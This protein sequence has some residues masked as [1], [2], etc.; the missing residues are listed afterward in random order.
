[1]NLSYGLDTAGT[2]P[3]SVVIAAT[4]ETGASLAWTM[5]GTTW[6]PFTGSFV[7]KLSGTAKVRAQVVGKDDSIASLKPFT[8]YHAN[9]APTVGLTAASLS[10]KSYLGT[11]SATVAKVTDWGIGDEI[12]T[13]TW[14]VQN[15]D[16]VDT[17]FVSKL[18]V[19]AGGKLS[20]TLPR[21]TS[22]VVKVRLRIKDN[23]GTS[24]GGVDLSAWT[25]WISI[26]IVDTVLDPKLNVYRAIRMPDGKTWMRSNLRYQV[27]SAPE[28][29]Y[30]DSCEKYGVQYSMYTAFIGGDTIAPT[31]G[32]CPAGWHIAEKND[33]TK[34]KLSTMD[35]G[36]AP[37]DSI[38][39]LR[40]IGA[41]AWSGKSGTGGIRPA[42]GTHGDFLYPN[43]SFAM[44]GHELWVWLPSD[45][46]MVLAPKTYGLQNGS[47]DASGPDVG[48]VRCVKD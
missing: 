15:F 22:V 41:W 33:W 44:Y 17:Q 39:G 47:L 42:T 5:D 24:S 28:A 46:E 23:G 4:S 12:Q 8:L 2:L 21:D 14:E 34:L 27:L 26:S 11:F 30:R 20:G 9:R 45:R 31:R 38:Y 48:A 1:L 32:A 6:T 29:C 36:V 25:D 37:G 35:H 40:A 43:G 10:A 7:Q 19:D 18:A 13:G 16:Q 3:D